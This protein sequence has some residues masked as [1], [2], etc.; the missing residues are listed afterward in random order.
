MKTW[1]I[2]RCT[3]GALMPIFA[4]LAGVAAHAAGKSKGKTPDAVKDMAKEVPAAEG[5]G[6][7]SVR[8]L[9]MTTALLGE[10]YDSFRWT[11]TEK[12][13]KALLKE[14]RGYVRIRVFTPFG[15]ETRTVEFGNGLPSKVLPKMASKEMAETAEKDT[16]DV[17]VSEKDPEEV[18]DEWIEANL[19]DLLASAA[20]EAVTVEQEKLPKNE[21]A[22]LLISEQLTMMEGLATT[23]DAGEGFYIAK[24][25]SE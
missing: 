22:C 9:S 8:I 13:L 14:G 10:E 15:S 4:I 19:P 17:L 5:P 23:Y 12:N 3:C 7:S 2:I 1:D 11:F 6:D 20:R 16:E 18:A 25:V 21:E 24:T